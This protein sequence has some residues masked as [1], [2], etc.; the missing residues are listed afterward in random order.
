[1]RDIRP[2]P[3]AR[4]GG[5]LRAALLGALVAGCAPS[6]EP[7]DWV[8]AREVTP[9]FLGRIAATDP[10]I[11]ADAHG[12]VA[13]TF[14]THD[15]SGTNLWLSL[16][17]DSGFT[18]FAP[19]QVNLA[20]GAVESQP[21][22]RPVAAFGTTGEFAVAWCERRQ[23]PGGGT[24]IVVR[25]SGDGGNTL[26]PPAVVN[27][28]AQQRARHATDWPWLWRHRWNLDPTHGSPAIEFLH[29]GSLVAVWIDGRDE[30][31]P[32]NRA[33][34][35]LYGAKSLD[36]GLTW[37]ENSRLAGDVCPCRPA[38]RA[39]ETGRIAVA[40]R[41]AHDAGRDPA[42]AIS[43]DRDSTFALD[44][45]I[46]ADRWVLHECPIQ[47]PG[48]TRNRSG[49]GHY[50]WVTGAARPGLYV[51]P[52]RDEHGAAGVKRWLSDSLH[53]ASGTQLVP[54][55]SRSLIGV[56]ARPAADTARVVFAVRS[57]E[58]SGALTPWSFLGAD[59]R[60][61]WLA[62]LDARTALACWA[63]REG[64]AH[65]VRVARLRLRPAR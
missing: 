9:G 10:A 31:A 60:A 52:W 56:D 7:E 33:S 23:A 6:S 58:A 8:A 11:A 1:V 45:L 63:E 3:C 15:S 53:H 34:R 57:L 32:G 19:V 36:G 65:R 14:V 49:G 47:G 48:L 64:D 27:D 61:G 2:H 37:S 29:D 22:S 54:V 42:L 40:Y 28:D 12:R 39:D 59:A 41:R 51:I 4:P 35:S 62:G 30:S 24:D 26:G 16:S 13:L 20:D 50:A 5:L 25:A 21:E 18:F 44:T 55:G 38:L 46:S 17:P 43:L